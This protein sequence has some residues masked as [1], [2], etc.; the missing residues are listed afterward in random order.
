[1][2]RECP[3]HV[4]RHSGKRLSPGLCGAPWLNLN[5]IARSLSNDHLFNACAIPE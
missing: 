4:E 2:L 1:M 5:A 3:G